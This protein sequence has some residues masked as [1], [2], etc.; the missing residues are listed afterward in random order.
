MTFIVSSEVLQ[1]KEPAII[2]YTGLGS[3]MLFNKNDLIPIKGQL[4]FE[5]S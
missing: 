4:I 1:L 5:D 3:R 2:D